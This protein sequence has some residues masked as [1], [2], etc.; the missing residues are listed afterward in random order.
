MPFQFSFIWKKNS[1][2][3]FFRK[4]NFKLRNLA[5]SKIYVSLKFCKPEVGWR[6][7]YFLYQNF[8]ESNLSSEFLNQWKNKQINFSSHSK[9]RG[10]KRTLTDVFPHRLEKNHSAEKN[11][12]KNTMDDKLFSYAKILLTSWHFH[13][14][15]GHQMVYNYYNAYIS[16]KKIPPNVSFTKSFRSLWGM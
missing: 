16:I 8:E 15:T 1:G 3:R 14:F 5:T 6:N 2:K 10:N 4:R 13:V 12:S 7:N 9:K 11:L